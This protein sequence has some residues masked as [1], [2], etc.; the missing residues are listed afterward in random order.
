MRQRLEEAERRA[1]EERL[2]ELE[3][4]RAEEEQRN[5]EKQE[6]AKLQLPDEP[7][8][9]AVSV[10]NIAF[11]LP[12]GS[13]IKRRFHDSSPVALLFTYIDASQSELPAE[14]YE[15]ISSFPRATLDDPEK[16]L[17]DYGLTKNALLLVQQI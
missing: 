7:E 16:T 14:S 13:R 3:R 6:K 1:E 11:K 17:Q 4:Q 9:G 2:A 8:E 5:K 15:L 10:I 12:S